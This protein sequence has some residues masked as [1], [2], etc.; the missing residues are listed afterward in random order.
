MSYES[1]LT[2]PFLKYYMVVE[3][4]PKVTGYQ[5]PSA[6]FLATGLDNVDL[7]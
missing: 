7:K 2:V 6:V 5:A 3:S 1:V 4:S